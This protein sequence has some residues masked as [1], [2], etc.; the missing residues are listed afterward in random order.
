[1]TVIAVSGIPASGKTTLA[2]ALGERLA[3]PVISKDDIKEALMDVLGSGDTEW[4]SQLS[5]A[6]HQVMFALVP[7]LAGHVIL[8]AHF[9]TGAAEA[10]LEAL[11]GDLIQVFCRCPVDVAWAR[12][13]LRRDD[14]NRH[15]GH[16]PEHQDH[17]ATAGW[18][19]REPAPLDLEAPLI[20]VD[21]SGTV[22]VGAVA[23][24]LR[25][26]LS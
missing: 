6:S 13:Q 25:R 26:L 22:D 11:P 9:H 4:A 7:S 17:A 16:L 8:E 3:L 12:Y 5:R 20:D 19:S 18:R 10:Q 1:M 15:P 2:R 21:T 23:A 24:Q 14:P